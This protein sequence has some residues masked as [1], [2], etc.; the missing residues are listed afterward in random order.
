MHFSWTPGQG[1]LRHLSVQLG[2][3]ASLRNWNRG[4]PGFEAPRFWL[5]L[6]WHSLHVALLVV[7]G[8]C[9]RVDRRPQGGTGCESCRHAHSFYHVLGQSC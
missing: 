1:I 3:F 9:C 4:S 8:L 5:S 6:L 2:D 7:P